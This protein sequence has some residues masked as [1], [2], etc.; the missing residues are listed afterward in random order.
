VKQTVLMLIPCSRVASQARVRVTTQGGD[1][2]TETV[3]VRPVAQQ[4]E[5]ASGA[6][7]MNARV[8]LDDLAA[9]PWAAYLW[10]GDIARVERLVEN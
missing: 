5:D 7:D 6:A 4:F 2:I 1:I 10:L 8:R 9:P 3:T